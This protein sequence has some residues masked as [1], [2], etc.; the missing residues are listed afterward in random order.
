MEDG[1][2]ENCNCVFEYIDYKFIWRSGLTL[3]NSAE[4]ARDTIIQ[5]KP[6][7]IY[8]L[9]GICDLTRVVSQDPWTVALR[10]PTVQATVNHYIYNLDATHQNIYSLSRYLGHNLMIIFP[11]LTGLDIARYSTHYPT[12]LRSPQQ[13]T[14]NQ[15]IINM[16]RHITATNR[17][18]N[19]STPFLATTVYPWCRRH[20]R[21]VYTHLF[22]GC[23]P[24]DQ[25]CAKWADKIFANA[26]TNVDK[27]LSYNLIN[28]MY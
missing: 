25:L 2:K 26:M 23:H 15:A 7:M 6:H 3:A 19:I 16:N 27:Y 12:G 8:I 13:I 4:F 14:L 18:M 24:T 10:F 21:F 28:A 20:Y 11:T 9:T 17:S 22:D 1:L 5:Y